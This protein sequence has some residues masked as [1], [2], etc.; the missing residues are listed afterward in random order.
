MC[1]TSCQHYFLRSELQLIGVF[2]S[3]ALLSC[4]NLPFCKLGFSAWSAR[5]VGGQYP[6]QLEQYHD[7]QCQ[8]WAQFGLAWLNCWQ[9]SVPERFSHVLAC[10]S[11]VSVHGRRGYSERECVEQVMGR[12]SWG[13]ETASW[14]RAGWCLLRSICGC[15]FL[16]LVCIDNYGIN[17]NI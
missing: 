13:S 10:Q 17:L 15:Y 8:G 12:G 3:S 11:P 16:V 4:S 6:V 7:L 1:S 5:A 2:L 14:C 9:P